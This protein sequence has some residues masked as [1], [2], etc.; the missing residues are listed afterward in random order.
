MNNTKQVYFLTPEA[1]LKY[2][3]NVSDE[4]DTLILCKSSEV[5]LKTTDQNLY[6]ALG[7]IM[8][9]DEFKN[10]KLVK[11]LEVVDIEHAEKKILTHE[12]VDE[13]RNIT[14]KK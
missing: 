14:L 5:T 4:I 10:N 3:L 7:S 6:E 9:Y 8:P 1:I 12:R 11:L 2:F 13:L